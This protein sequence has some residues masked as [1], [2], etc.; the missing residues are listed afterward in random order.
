MGTAHIIIVNVLFT[1][2]RHVIGVAF[3]CMPIRCMPIWLLYNLCLS[4]FAT[5]SVCHILN[6]Q[7]FI[8]TAQSVSYQTRTFQPLLH[9]KQQ[10]KNTSQ[11][12]RPTVLAK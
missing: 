6:K 10:K 11:L 4:L 7:M 3:R 5:M 12:F 8:V 1:F 9:K 2:S